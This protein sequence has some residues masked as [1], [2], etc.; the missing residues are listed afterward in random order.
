V[1]GPRQRVER[2]VRCGRCGVRL[3]LFGAGVQHDD[4]SV[5]L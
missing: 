3:L 4:R 1:R 2:V 5:R